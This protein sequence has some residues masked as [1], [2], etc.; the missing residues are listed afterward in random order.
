M[1]EH[2]APRMVGTEPPNPLDFP[3]KDPLREVCQGRWKQLPSTQKIGLIVM[4]S[5][6]VVFVATVVFAAGRAHLLGSLVP[7]LF[8]TSL[9][10]VLLLVLRRKA[11]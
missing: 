11:R 4:L 6:W 2:K 5:I 1:K 7:V 3:V 9:L 10:G 8:V